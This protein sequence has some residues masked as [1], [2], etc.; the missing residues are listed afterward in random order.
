[1]NLF[2]KISPLATLI[3]IMLSLS[4]L[5]DVAYVAAAGPKVSEL[6]PGNAS[7]NKHNLSAI[8]RQFGTKTYVENVNTYRATNDT[9]DNSRGQ[10]ICVFCH[11]PHSANV[12]G[13]APLWNRAFST[14]NFQRYS[15][16]T[17][18][19]RSITDALYA[20]G[21][22][23]SGSSKLCLSCHDGVSRLGKLY[24]GAEIVMVGGGDVI[25]G[26]ASFKPDTNKMK[27]GHHPVSFKYTAAIAST[28]STGKSGTTYTMSS[29][30]S[31]VKLDKQGMM[32]CTTCHDPHQNQ[33]D[34]IV[35]ACYVA[36]VPGDCAAFPNDRKIAPFW[37]Y[38]GSGS[39][40]SGDQQAVCISCHPMDAGASF[41]GPWPTP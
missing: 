37:V 26:I 38:G 31:F 14:E 35:N 1:M 23:P 9:V 16:S 40:A 22:Q 13:Q 3:A 2:R 4:C 33:S 20:D 24:T 7:G 12:D 32:Q 8:A 11:T 19:I 5:A 25:S 10:Q 34:D 30:P 28:I 21:A 15:S 29:M 18:Q 39:G 41:V 6:A 17:L 36:G 27:S